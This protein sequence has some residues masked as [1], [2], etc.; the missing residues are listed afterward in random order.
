MM[1]HGI[2]S[3]LQGL[4]RNQ[5]DFMKHADRISQWGN[6]GVGNNGQEIDL[7]EELLGTMT[8]RRGF[9]ANLSVLRAEDDML[10]SLLDVMA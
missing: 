5:H 9:E 6:S 10:G 2:N 8:A 7:A 1:I 4:Q 3:S